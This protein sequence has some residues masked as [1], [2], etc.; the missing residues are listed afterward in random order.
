M[1]RSLGDILHRDLLFF[2]LALILLL[3]VV[4][5]L[6]VESAVGRDSDYRAAALGTA[7]V[8]SRIGEVV[9]AVSV[10]HADALVIN[11]E[12]VVVVVAEEESLRRAELLYRLEQIVFAHAA[13]DYL[14]A[15][16][17]LAVDILDIFRVLEAVCHVFVPCVAL[18]GQR[19][20][21]EREGLDIRILGQTQLLETLVVLLVHEIYVVP[22]PLNLVLMDVVV[23]PHHAEEVAVGVRVAV[24][25]V[26]RLGEDALGVLDVYD[27]VAVAVNIVGT[28]LKQAVFE[29][30]VA[31]EVGNLLAGVVAVSLGVMVAEGDRPVDPEMLHESGYFFGGQLVVECRRLEENGER[32]VARYNNEVGLL[33]LDHRGDCVYRLRVLLER[34]PAAA[35]MYVGQLHDLEIAVGRERPVAVLVLLGHKLI[36]NDHRVIALGALDVRLVADNRYHND[37]NNKQRENAEDRACDYQRSLFLLRVFLLFLFHFCS[38]HDSSDFQYVQRHAFF[39]AGAD[40]FLRYFIFVRIFRKCRLCE[41]FDVR[42]RAAVGDV[43]DRNAEGV[44][45][46]RYL[47]AFAAADEVEHHSTRFFRELHCRGYQHRAD[48]K[49]EHRVDRKLDILRDGET[50]DRGEGYEAVENAVRRHDFYYRRAGNSVDP[51]IGEEHDELHRD[52]DYQHHEIARQIRYRRRIEQPLERIICEIQPS[53]K[54]YHRHDERKELLRFFDYRVRALAR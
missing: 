15:L 9:D 24:K 53:E 19:N 49:P 41:R 42:P 46:F 22:V 36:L 31:V 54:Y 23:F 18:F 28:L 5:R 33:C 43:I 13:V 7:L 25:Y 45:Y 8:D 14:F 3:I 37:G 11:R 16:T 38:F 50:H 40:K 29:A 12:V 4:L 10:S 26:E 52:R 39:F 30:G 35:E 51:A 27:L 34:E 32:H 48:N 21:E 2:V 1:S 17:G 47:F 20:V 44:K 6:A